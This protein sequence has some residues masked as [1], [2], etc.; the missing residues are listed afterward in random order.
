MVARSS[1]YSL[2]KF[3][4]ISGTI[5]LPSI[6]NPC[7]LWDCA[8]IK[9]NEFCAIPTLKNLTLDGLYIGSWHGNLPWVILPTGWTC[10]DY[11]ECPDEDVYWCCFDVRLDDTIKKSW[12]SQNHYVRKHLQGALDTTDCFITTRINFNCTLNTCLDSFTLQGTFM[13]DAPTDKVYLFLFS[14]QVEIVDGQ[15][16]VT[17]PPDTEKYY[18]AF[19][20]DGLDRLT[21]ETAED[22]GLLSVEFSTRLMGGIWDKHHY[23]MVRDFHIAKGFDPYSQDAA[24][25]MGYPLIDVKEMKLSPRFAGG[26]SMD[27]P[28]VEVEDVI[29]YSLGLC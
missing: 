19:D 21:S 22:I 20:P 17:S 16:T 24:I 15:I 12:L 2:K 10:V 8:H 7:C 3:P 4:P 26:N 5:M 9:P 27:C 6:C 11:P 18:W 28:D 23:D 1:T 25:A 29:Y 13:A 14:P